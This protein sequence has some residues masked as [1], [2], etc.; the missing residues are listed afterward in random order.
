MGW[1]S[2]KHPNNAECPG[3]GHG[4]CSHRRRSG[5][6]AGGAGRCALLRPVPRPLLP[7]HSC[8][9]LKNTPLSGPPWTGLPR[10]VLGHEGWSPDTI[11]FFASLQPK[12]RVVPRAA[13]IPLLHGGRLRP[14]AARRA[15]SGSWTVS[16]PVGEPR[17]PPQSLSRC[18]GLFAYR[19]SKSSAQELQAMVGVDWAEA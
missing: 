3:S 16:P 1:K 6:T 15:R 14:R 11:S 9:A 4:C 8:P 19:K 10:K 12:R 2:G 18:S 13:L 5:P 7:L 17:V